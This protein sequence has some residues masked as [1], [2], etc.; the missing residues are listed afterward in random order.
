[1]MNMIIDTASATTAMNWA[2]LPRLVPG[3]G[4]GIW[5]SVYWNGSSRTATID[6]PCQK[7]RAFDEEMAFFR[8]AAGIAGRLPRRT[9]G[10][11]GTRLIPG[12]LN[13][14]IRRGIFFWPKDRRSSGEL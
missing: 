8:E 10:A 2:S 7:S 11:P 4:G 5:L 6:Q 13:P 1:M 9:L 12:N 3:G 14:S